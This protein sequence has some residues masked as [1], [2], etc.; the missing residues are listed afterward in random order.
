MAYNRRDIVFN[1]MKRRTI[2][3]ELT[4][5]DKPSVLKEW[6]WW[7]GICMMVLASL[8]DFGIFLFDI[9]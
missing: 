9:N 6:M 1:E 8:F 2:G 7:V 5:D 3:K 4:E